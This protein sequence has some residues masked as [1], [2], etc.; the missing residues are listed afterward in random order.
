MCCFWFVLFVMTYEWLIKL[1]RCVEFYTNMRANLH[2][3]TKMCRY[4]FIM[5]IDLYIILLHTYVYVCLFKFVALPLWLDVLCAICN[6]RFFS[7]IYFGLFAFAFNIYLFIFFL[8]FTFFYEYYSKRC[9]LTRE[10][11]CVFIV[12]STMLIVAKYCCACIFK[13]FCLF[14]LFLLARFLFVYYACCFLFFAF[15]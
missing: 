9:R 11:V 7:T 5:F 15:I 12:A 8:L 4:F 10:G 14:L 2:E 13:L 6:L 1:T 3:Q